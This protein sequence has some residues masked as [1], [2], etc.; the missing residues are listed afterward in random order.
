MKKNH[1]IVET[2]QVKP[3]FSRI[4]SAFGCPELGSI[5]A[6]NV[7]DASDSNWFCRFHF[8]ETADRWPEITRQ[9]R[10]F[11]N[12][13]REPEKPKVIV[14]PEYISR[15]KEELRQFAK[16][17]GSPK[18]PKAWAK[19]LRAKE[20]AGEELSDAQRNAW[21]TALHHHEEEEV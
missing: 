6:S 21:R 16:S 1:E 20:I 10:L 8:N 5:T 17:F 14:T 2:K 18:D 11:W 15:V 13:Y 9:R 12:D 7:G 4:C 3:A 19:R